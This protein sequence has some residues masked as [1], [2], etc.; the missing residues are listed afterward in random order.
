MAPARVVQNTGGNGQNNPIVIE[1]HI[2]YQIPRAPGATPTTTRNPP[3]SLQPIQP[4][5]GFAGPN[6]VWQRWPN[7]DVAPVQTDTPTE[8]VQTN[9]LGENSAVSHPADAQDLDGTENTDTE[10]PR[11][12]AALAA[13]RRSNGDSPASK[14]ISPPLSASSTDKSLGK[15][16]ESRVHTSPPTVPQLIPLFNLSAP[17]PTQTFPN[18]TTP[19]AV[20]SQDTPLLSQ[21]PRHIT[22]AQLALMDE[23]TREAIDERLRILENVSGTVYQCVE[24]LLRLRSALPVTQVLTENS[25]QNVS[26]EVN[27]GM[28]GT[29]GND[30]FSAR[31]EGKGKAVDRSTEHEPGQ[32][33]S[34]TSGSPAS[35]VNSRR[36][37]GGSEDSFEMY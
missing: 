31:T 37:E 34:K 10:N 26:H 18:K 19:P 13:L 14:K 35:G 11:T 32:S 3:A 1:Y 2:Q 17:P 5:E 6:G 29:S 9:P 23:L 27:G 7:H 25:Q 28:E 30:S 36:E 12:A 24:D 21:L 33:M 8:P 15:T 16:P 4:L 22:D 20:L